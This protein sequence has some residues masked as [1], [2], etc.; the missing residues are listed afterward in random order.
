[1][2]NRRL[3]PTGLATPSRTR[4]L[5]CTGPGLDRHEAAG[6]VFGRF[7][8]RTELFFRS[9]LGPLGGYPD[10]LLT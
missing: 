5:T 7:W 9:K 10:L 3:D 6:Q 4:R 2:Q 1:M 8:T